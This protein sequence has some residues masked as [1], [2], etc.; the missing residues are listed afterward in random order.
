MSAYANF[1]FASLS[2]VVELETIQVSHPNFSHDYF[3]VRNASAGMTARLE[4]G[5]FVNF[6]YYPA[7]I[8]RVSAQTDLDQQLQIDLGDL[9]K[10]IPLEVD[11]IRAAS[12]FITKPTVVFRSYRSD[13][14]N[15]VMYGPVRLLADSIAFTKTGSTVLANA[16]QLNTAETGETYTVD[17]FPMLNGLL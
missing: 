9:G 17:R 7:R 8:S 11:R 5:V 14:L 15:T 16:P 3:F 6:T 1:F 12:N 2:A 4:T 13:N 10:V